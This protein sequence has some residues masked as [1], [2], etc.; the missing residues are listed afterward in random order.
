MLFFFSKKRKTSIFAQ[1]NTMEIKVR[2]L[3]K[4]VIAALDDQARAQ[5]KSR[6]EYLAEQL[7]LLARG[8]ELI[9]QE[10]QYRILLEKMFAV[11]RENTE[12]MDMLLNK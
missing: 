11:V 1:K 3:D 2:N 10:D 8:P 5:K 6:N 4:N 9:Q 7:T 12:V